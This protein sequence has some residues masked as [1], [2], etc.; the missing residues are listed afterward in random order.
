MKK[1]IIQATALVILIFIATYA[2]FKQD[3]ILNLALFS[4]TQAPSAQSKLQIGNTRIDLEVADT[5]DK[6]AKGLGG[7]DFLGENSGMLFVFDKADKYRFWMKGMKISLDFIW[8]RDDT[9]VDILANVPFPPEGA[10]PKSLPVY[11][12]IAPVNKML[13]VNAG[14]AASH[15]IRVGDKVIMP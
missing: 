5:E 15:G 6:R 1:F 2:A 8:I 3:A 9:V 12:P 4:N 14:F 10:D 13:E 11:E 7:R